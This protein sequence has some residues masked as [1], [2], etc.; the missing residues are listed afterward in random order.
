M[1]CELNT[2]FEHLFDTFWLI[3][4]EELLSR[5][6]FDPKNRLEISIFLQFFQCHHSKRPMGA[7]LKLDPLSH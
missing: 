3:S 7:S 5:L 1:M 6:L 2:F 4:L